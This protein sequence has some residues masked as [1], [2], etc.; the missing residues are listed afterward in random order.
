M[1]MAN[2]IIRNVKPSPSFIFTQDLLVPSSSNSGIETIIETVYDNNDIIDSI[3]SRKI[4]HALFVKKKSIVSAKTDTC[5]DSSLS[6]FHYYEDIKL[7]RNTIVYSGII[8][9]LS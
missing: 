9:S 2:S 4:G 3:Y 7:P 8:L 5:H 6:D 1:I